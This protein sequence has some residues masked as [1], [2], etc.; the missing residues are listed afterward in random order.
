MQAPR[1]LFMGTAVPSAPQR[2]GAGGYDEPPPGGAEFL[3]R[4]VAGN[5]RQLGRSPSTY[6]SLADCRAGV[7]RLLSALPDLVAVL[8]PGSGA[9][10][11][12]WH[13][14]L[15]G[16]HG[17]RSVL[18][19]SSRSYERQ[20]ENR[21]SIENFRSAAAIAVVSDG[22]VLRARP[23]PG[24]SSMLAPRSCAIPTQLSGRGSGHATHGGSR[25]RTIDLN[26]SQPRAG[27]P[28]GAGS[29]LPP[30]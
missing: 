13:L 7:T 1:F 28:A 21:Y 30:E 22:V 6:S 15:T 12:A 14:V 5:N 18:A 25:G 26:A 17:E 3:W 24:S 2:S 19:A 4:L 20:R 8:A 23:R 9:G 27:T 29:P 11:W 10:R 16:P